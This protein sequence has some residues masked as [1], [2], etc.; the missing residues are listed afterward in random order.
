MNDNENT[1]LDTEG[2]FYTEGLGVY[3]AY[4]LVTSDQTLRLDMDG[5][6]WFSLDDVKCLEKFLKK[7]RKQL[8]AGV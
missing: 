4:E 1:P 2:F 8:K 3:V 6:L 5:G 7:A